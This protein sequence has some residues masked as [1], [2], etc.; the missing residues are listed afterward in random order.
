MVWRGIWS[1]STTYAVNDG[2][3]RTNQSYICV[4]A[5]TGGDPATD[6]THWNLLAA[7]GGPGPTAISADAG[8]TASLGTDHLVFVPAPKVA[9]IGGILKYVSTTQLSFL[10]FKGSGIQING[11]VYNI[12]PT[13]VVGLASTGIYIDGVA[14]QNFAVST[15]YYVYC[16]NNAGVLTADFSTTGHA[17]SSTAGN[18]GTEI[19]SGDDTRTLIGLIRII[20]SGGFTDSPTVRFTRSWFNR[21]RLPFAA[22]GSAASSGGEAATA[23]TVS[24]VCFG[25]DALFASGNA[26]GTGSVVANY[27]LFMELD[28][29]SI[30]RSACSTTGTTA[31]YEPTAVQGAWNPSEGYH[32]VALYSSMSAGTFSGTGWMSGIL[33]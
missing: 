18:V 13:G 33:G 28:G 1:S 5:N 3:S 15:N 26:F 31:K 19:K 14:G 10:P 6:T 4:V 2:V 29:V 24:L 11:V 23:V 7:Q 32:V 12:P 17:T 20:S 8:N 16:F 22:S 30:S 27:T 25:D 9:Q 21:G